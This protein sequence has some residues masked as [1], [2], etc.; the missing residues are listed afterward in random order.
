VTQ[1]ILSK[2]YSKA[3]AVKVELEEKQ[4][5]KAREREK[6]GEVWQ[7]VFFSQVTDKGGK[8][9]LTDKG[10]EVLNRA[11]NGEWDIKDLLD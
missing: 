10:R 9:E 7:P 5:E 8:P 1:A 11:Q 6:T 4:R 2:Q 3:T